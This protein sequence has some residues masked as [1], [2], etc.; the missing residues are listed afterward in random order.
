MLRKGY[1]LAVG[2]S[3]VGLLLAI[4]IMRHY[5]KVN[6]LESHKSQIT[7]LAQRQAAA[8]ESELQKFT[9]LPNVLSETQYV[10][11]A[12]QLN[13][14]EEL[15]RLNQKLESIA[16]ITTVDYIYVIDHLGK[17]IAS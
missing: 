2:V 4:F 7:A 6:A 15:Q 17:T 3:V 14:P 5:A 16:N 12:L 10:H 11:S 1:V 13:T 9:L 8:L